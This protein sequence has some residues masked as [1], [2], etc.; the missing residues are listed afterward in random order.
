MRRKRDHN[1]GTTDGW[2]EI[3]VSVMRDYKLVGNGES[4]AAAPRGAGTLGSVE[5]FEDVR[6]I[7]GVDTGAV[8]GNGQN[9]ASLIDARLYFDYE[10]SAGRSVFDGIG[11]QVG[12]DLTETSRITVDEDRV[13]V[14]LKLVLVG[15]DHRSH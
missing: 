5:A 3:D 14:L 10:M 13:E 11:K 8:V 9:C 12:D 2:R 7:L 1:G 6:P 15:V 4:D